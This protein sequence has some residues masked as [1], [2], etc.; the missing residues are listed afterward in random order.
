LEDAAFALNKG[1]ISE[2]VKTKYGWHVIKCLDNEGLATYNEMEQQLKAKVAKDSRSSLSKQSLINRIKKEY[3]FKEKLKSKD[4]LFIK[5][6]SSILRGRWKAESA[7]GMKSV[8]FQLL[9]KKYTQNDFA[10]FIENNPRLRRGNSLN[11]VYS[12][13][14]NQFVE[15]SCMDFEESRL[16]EKYPDFKELMGEYFD[17]ILLFEIT[18]EKVWSKAV[19][20]TTGLEEY[21]KKN[22]ENYMWDER[23]NA[24]IYKCSDHKVAKKAKA[25]L[26]RKNDDELLKEFNKEKSKE[27]LKIESGTYERG[28]DNYID[29]VLWEI[30]LS[31]EITL[32]DGRVVFIKIA[33][34]VEPEP[35]KLKEI[36]GQVIADYQ[37]YL[38]DEWIKSLK[39]KYPVKVNDSVLKSLVK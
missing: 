7:A 19:N 4:K 18:D 20:D 15:T 3:N 33:G 13:Y 24:T 31:K 28:Q 2:P 34:L 23:V 17:G 5:I 39:Q 36:K 29:R 25:T 8:I 32:D 27:S 26:E 37:E 12:S 22:S 35:K 14:Y 38:E 9:K 11:A 6:D 30:G 21:F 10:E 16:E 1:D